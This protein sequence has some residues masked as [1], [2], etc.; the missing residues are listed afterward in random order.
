[1]KRIDDSHQ[2]FKRTKK[3]GPGPRKRPAIRET[4]TFVCKRSKPT[5]THYIQQCAYTGADGARHV[6]TVRTKKTWKKKYNKVYRQWAAKRRASL[7]A[8]G[9]QRS[10]R[11][12][13]TASTKC[14]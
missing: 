5:K 13:R 9:P 7:V 2:P 11:C 14:R 3:I 1:M 12:R 4:K 10:Y 6:T 8:R